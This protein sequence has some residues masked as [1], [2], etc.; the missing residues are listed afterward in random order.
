[1]GRLRER[2]SPSHRPEQHHGGVTVACTAPF[3]RARV[4]ANLITVT[5]YRFLDPMG[6]VVAEGEFDEHADALAWA[7]DDEREDDLQRVEYLGPEGTWRWVGA[8]SG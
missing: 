7:E 3:R 4:G 5:R 6:D 8:L 2:W 1:V